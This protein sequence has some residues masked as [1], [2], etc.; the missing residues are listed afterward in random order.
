MLGESITAGIGL[1]E[2]DLA[3]HRGRLGALAVAAALGRHV[4]AGCR[5][6]APS[7]VVDN[8]HEQE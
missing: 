2:A 3:R 5:W 1:R 8:A 4:E 6:R 7:R